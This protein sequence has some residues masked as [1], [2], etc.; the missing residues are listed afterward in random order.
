MPQPNDLFNPNDPLAPAVDDPFADDAVL[1]DEALSAP[2][3]SVD[4]FAGEATL[5]AD[6]F[7][8]PAELASCDHDADAG[9]LSVAVSAVCEALETSAF[10]SAEPADLTDSAT[11]VD[12][13]RVTL[14]FGGPA[15]GT[16]CLLADANL[17]RTLVANA[18]GLSEDDPAVD[19]EM[20]DALRE[21]VN[22]AVGAMMPRLVRDDD[23]ECP[24]GLPELA[25]STSDEWAAARTSGYAALDAE[26]RPLLVGLLPAA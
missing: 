5:P 3:G 7:A 1:L 8:E 24:L 21:L 23:A 12:S 19:G 15:A 18:V 4:P 2:R 13:R 11:P 20:D 6:P 10:I 16:L 14:S 25:G 9:P 22:V 17:G 26:G